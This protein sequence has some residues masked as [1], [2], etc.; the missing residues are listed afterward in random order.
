MTTDRKLA[1]VRRIAG[2]D[3]IPNSDNLMCV[4]VDGWK[5]VS[6]KENNFQVGELVIYFEV[7]SFLPVR[8]E[9]EWLRKSSFKT[10]PGLGEGFR[11]K[12]IK[13]RGQVSQGLIVPMTNFLEKSIDGTWYYETTDNTPSAVLLEEGSD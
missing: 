5:L 4:T 1:S 13:L 8:E 10:V 2:I 11:I 7:D 12:T 6:N 3:T 9:F